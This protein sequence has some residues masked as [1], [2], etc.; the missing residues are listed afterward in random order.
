MSAI[1]PF[2]PRG[3]IVGVDECFP[4]IGQVAADGRLSG[5]AGV[6]S[7]Q[8]DLP[9]GNQHRDPVN[10]GLDIDQPL[11][12][13]GRT[14]AETSEAEN[15]IRAARAGLLDTEQSILMEARRPMSTSSRKKASLSSISTT[16]RF[17]DG[18]SERRKT[19]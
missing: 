1:R 8:A 15:N 13:G 10:F 7:I 6:S 4:G 5:D 17:C 19:V 14:L 16:S 18:S 3:P 11:F 2:C 12:R 9:S